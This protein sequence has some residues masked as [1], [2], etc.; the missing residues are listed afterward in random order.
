MI[1]E[2]KVI[3]KGEKTMK[4]KMNAFL[5][6]TL[7]L[8]VVTI[9]HAEMDTTL[10][11]NVSPLTMSEAKSDLKTPQIA[12]NDTISRDQINHLTLA[13]KHPESIPHAPTTSANQDDVTIAC[14][15]LYNDGSRTYEGPLNLSSLIKQTLYKQK[16]EAAYPS[17]EPNTNCR[18][19]LM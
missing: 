2:I 10:A 15:I 5:L 17:C 19:T 8:S 18:W 6:A 9:A 3:L 14:Y 13:Q 11:K 1:K 16:C 4:R 12:M 7:F